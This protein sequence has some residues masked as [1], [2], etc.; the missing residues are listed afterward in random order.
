VKEG[1]NFNETFNCDLRIHITP[2]RSKPELNPNQVS[3][4]ID[5]RLDLARLLWNMDCIL[6]NPNLRNPSQGFT[7]VENLSQA[8]SGVAR[9]RLVPRVFP[10]WPGIF[11]SN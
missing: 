3:S 6:V 9:R 5:D 7:V 8:L 4:H 1:H 10:I 2:D 11:R